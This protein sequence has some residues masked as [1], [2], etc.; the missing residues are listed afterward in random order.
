MTA[1]P[2]QVTRI[3]TRLTTTATSARNAFVTGD[4]SAAAAL[5]TIVTAV[6]LLLHTSKQITRALD[7]TRQVATV[8]AANDLDRA[9]ITTPLAHGELVAGHTR[10]SYD[11]TMLDALLATVA[12]RHPEIARAVRACRKETAYRTTYRFT[13]PK[14]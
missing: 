12:E 13:L 7:D 10:V 4:I 11:A 8:I 2:A 6:P 3:I 5:T 9:E 14:K 1:T